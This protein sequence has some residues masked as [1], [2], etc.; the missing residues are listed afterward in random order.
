MATLLWSPFS[1]LMVT[2]LCTH[3]LCTHDY[4]SCYF[5]MGEKRKS[6][7]LIGFCDASCQAYAAVVHLQVETGNRC[8][9]RFVAAKIRVSPMQDHS[10]PCLE[11]LGALPVSRL[12]ASITSALNPELELDAPTYFTDFNIVLFWIQGHDKEW[13]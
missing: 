10:I 7:S 5:N 6:C 9:V 8:Y 2:L 3:L 13:R 12:L 4:P 11:L 1:A